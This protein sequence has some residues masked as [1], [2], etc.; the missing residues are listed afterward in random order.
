MKKTAHYSEAMD[1]LNA[2]IPEDNCNQ[3]HLLKFTEETLNKKVDVLM[4]LGCGS[5]Q[6]ADFLSKFC[7]KYIGLDIPD[8]PESL[9]RTRKDYEFLSF[10]G[11]NIPYPD[12]SI[13]MIFMNQV[14]EHVLEPHK[15][16]PEIHRVLKDTGILLGAVSQLEPFHSYSILNYTPYGLCAFLNLFKLQVFRLRP[17]IDGKLLIDRTLNK[18]IVN[19]GSSLEDTFWSETSPLNYILQKFSMRKKKTNKDINYTMLLL[20]GQFCFAAK[21]V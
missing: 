6:S 19:R 7:N 3:Y 1:I 14:L 9:R 8:S 13:D 12:N 16:I 11:Q 5:G 18:F 2:A 15:L 20:C 21:K 17:G 10:D 4:D